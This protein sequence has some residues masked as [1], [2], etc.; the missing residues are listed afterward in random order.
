MNN[1]H[2]NA[3]I[4]MATIISPDIEKIKPRR[5]WKT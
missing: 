3:D 1:F 2:L 4:A 5:R